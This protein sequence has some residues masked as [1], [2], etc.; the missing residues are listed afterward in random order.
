[1]KYV[2]G[3][4][5]QLR[6]YLRGGGSSKEHDQRQHPLVTAG[7]GIPMPPSLLLRIKFLM[8]KVLKIKH[9]KA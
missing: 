8:K 5:N 9:S 7:R 1:M 2:F 3:A 4:L 6:E